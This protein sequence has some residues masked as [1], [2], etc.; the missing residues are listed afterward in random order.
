MTLSELFTND[1]LKIISSLCSSEEHQL[2]KLRT[3]IDKIHLERIE[4]SIETIGSIKYKVDI[5]LEGR[6]KREQQ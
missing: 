4:A 5:I 1:E 6:L 2:H 3:T